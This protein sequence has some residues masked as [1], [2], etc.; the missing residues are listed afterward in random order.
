MTSCWSKSKTG[1][2]HPYY[3]CF[4]KGCE[5]SRKSIPRARMEEEFATLLC[6]VR[7]TRSLFD[8]AKAMF[9]D[10]WDGQLVQAKSLAAATRS[11]IVRI[12][13]QIEG[14]LDRI[15][16]ASNPSVINAYEQRI[17]KLEREKLVAAERSETLGKPL[18]PFGEMFELSLR[19]LS[20]PC[21]IWDSER[22]EDKRTVLQLTFLDGLSYCRKGG[23]RTPQLSVPFT[24]LGNSAEFCEMAEQA[25]SCEPVS[26][27]V[28][29]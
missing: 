5:S 14:L 3:M 8:L 16:E 13:R 24:L 6:G 25:V 7:P 4:T 9:R 18:R 29:C 27:K 2:K 12:E 21:K 15:V 1:K 23:F 28:A 26:G 11:E 22:L 10:A 17:A 20:N 19:F